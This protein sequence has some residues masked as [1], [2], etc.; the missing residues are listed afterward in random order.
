MNGTKAKS[1][2]RK[3][4]IEAGVFLLEQGAELNHKD[5]IKEQL[6]TCDYYNHPKENSRRVSQYTIRWF[7]KQEK[8]KNNK[9]K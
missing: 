7:I 1:L 6:P 2:R 3:A 8:N 9:G 4:M 5:D